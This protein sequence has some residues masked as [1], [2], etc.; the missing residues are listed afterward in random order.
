M[1]KRNEKLF[2]KKE[3]IWTRMLK[4]AVIE[5]M[6]EEEKIIPHTKVSD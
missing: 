6:H 3:V 4:A 1:T 2:N 5:G